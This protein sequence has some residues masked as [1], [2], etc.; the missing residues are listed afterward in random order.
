MTENRFT[1]F[2]DWWAGRNIGSSAG[3]FLPHVRPG[4]ALLDCGCGPGSITIDFAEALAPSEVVG[5]DVNT[6]ALQRA[7]RAAEERGVKSVRFEEASIYE[8]PF[9]DA[10]FDAVWTSSTIQWLRRPRLALN[11]VLRVLKPGG[12]YGSRDR[13]T[14]GDIFGNSNP[15]VRL[16]WRLHYRLNA[17]NGLSPR[18][19]EK[20]RGML[21]ETGFERVISSASYENHGGWDGA[22]FASQLYLNALSSGFG[23]EMVKRNWI[24][25]EKRERLIAAW[26][27][28]GSD[29]KS[30]YAICRVDNVGWKPE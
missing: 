12:V 17:H 9:A 18:L 28:W 21:I 10:T 7:R 22:R 16:A 2:A 26:M 29:P 27:E 1:S 25:R 11:E 19:A 8:L 3:F 4:M 15:N 20:L 14:T 24:N 6:A 13:C 30:Y 23:E 5:I